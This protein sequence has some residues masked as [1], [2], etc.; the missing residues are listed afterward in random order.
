VTEQTKPGLPRG[1]ASTPEARDAVAELI[2]GEL[3]TGLSIKVACDIVGVTNAWYYRWKKLAEQG[4]EEAIGLMRK[5]AAARAKGFKEGL[6]RIKAKADRT[7]D[8]RADA[9]LNDKLYPGWAGDRTTIEEIEYTLAEQQDDSKVSEWATPE[10]LLPIVQFAVE[11]GLVPIE[12]LLALAPRS[13]GRP[14]T[15]EPPAAAQLDTIRA[16]VV[17]QLADGPREPAELREVVCALTGCS[18]DQFKQACN[19]LELEQDFSA[20]RPTMVKLANTPT[21]Q[22]RTTPAVESPEAASKS[23]SESTT[24]AETSGSQ[25]GSWFDGPAYGTGDMIAWRRGR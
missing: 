5:L 2:C 21:D 10:R 24:A 18:H 6:G 13:A 4:N 9:W 8:W 20:G 11:S 1:V 14:S 23:G 12:Q 15:T 3:E 19:G 7:D 17:N 22:P 16:E 25:R